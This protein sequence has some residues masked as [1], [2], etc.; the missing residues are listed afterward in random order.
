MGVLPALLSRIQSRFL[1]EVIG[2]YGYLPLVDGRDIGQA[3][4]RAALAPNLPFYESINIVGPEVPSQ[5][6]VYEFMQTDFNCPRPVIKLP[7]RLFQLYS[8]LTGLIRY[9]E[10]PLLPRPLAD[11]ITNPLINNDK[12]STL[13]GYNPEVHWK[14]SLQEY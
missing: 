9:R 2:N 4:A 13:I 11:F 5:K 14:A 10:Q 6:A 12:S 3:F 1:A 7:A 8:S